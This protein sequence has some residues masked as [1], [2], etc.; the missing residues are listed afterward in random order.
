MNLIRFIDDMLTA[1]CTVYKSCRELLHVLA[2]EIKPSKDKIV[3]EPIVHVSNALADVQHD[4]SESSSD[5]D[6]AVVTQAVPSVVGVKRDRQAALL[7]SNSV[8]SIDEINPLVNVDSLYEEAWK[9]LNTP[10]VVIDPQSLSNLLAEMGVVEKELL[11]FCEEEDIERIAKE[12]RLIP[13]RKFLE[14]F[15]RWRS[16]L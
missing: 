1:Q 5:D 6:E 15:K 2:T 16:A 3:A 9:L 4:I 14:L 11:A 8:C 13:K 7:S 10:S 12:L